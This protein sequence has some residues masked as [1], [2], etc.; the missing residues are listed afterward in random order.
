[1]PGNDHV[2]QRAGV[3][4]DGGTIHG[5]GNVHP[6]VADVDADARRAIGF[7]IL[8]DATSLAKSLRR[9]DRE[10]LNLH[11]RPLRQRLVLQG[12]LEMNVALRAIGHERLCARRF[13]AGEAGGLNLLGRE[14]AV[15]PRAR[16][17]AEGA[18]AVPLPPT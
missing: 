2:L 3:I 14:V 17:A 9:Y 1:M 15:D 7:R 16:P 12:A 11:S 18:L 6:S 8:H 4:G 10:I 13:G 5:A